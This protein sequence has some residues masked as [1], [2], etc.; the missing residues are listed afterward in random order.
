MI[1]S[2]KLLNTVKEKYKNIF[3]TTTG[4]SLGGSLAEDSGGDKI[5]THNKG[6]G[7]GGL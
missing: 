4:D 2:K 5:I 6:T 3:I 1:Y 7:I